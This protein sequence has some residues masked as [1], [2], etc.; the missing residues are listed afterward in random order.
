MN[1]PVFGSSSIV[2]SLV[3]PHVK[4][5]KTTSFY[6]SQKDTLNVIAAS[7]LNDISSNKN[8]IVLGIIPLYL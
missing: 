7:D 1:I 4:R 3:T 2:I 5:S 8:L 6:I